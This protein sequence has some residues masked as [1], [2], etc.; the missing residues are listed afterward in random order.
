M[1]TLLT[2]TILIFSVSRQTKSIKYLSVF[3]GKLK[4][5]VIIQVLMAMSIFMCCVFPYLSFA[6]FRFRFWVNS[7]STL[8]NILQGCNNEYF[9]AQTTNF[10][11]SNYWSY[12][13][14]FNDQL[15]WISDNSTYLVLCILKEAELFFC[16]FFWKEY[17]IMLTK[18][19]W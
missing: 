6:F 17:N 18:L 15:I 8:E 4:K 1:S 19:N 7:L 16:S 3:L 5:Y 9:H 14:T 2:T 10:D 11:N 13:G 12:F